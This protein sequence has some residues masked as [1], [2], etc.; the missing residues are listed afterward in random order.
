MKNERW[1]I[2]K[3]SLFVVS[4][5]SGAGK[6]TLCYEVSK[7]IPD[8]KYSIS[9]TTR[10]PRSGE[11]NHRDY[12]F[13]TTDKFK[14]MIE[15]GEFAE[16]AEVHGNFY[17]TPIK[18]LN[19]L[20]NQNDVILDIDTQGAMQMKRRYGEGVYIFILPPS[21]EVLEERIRK[22]MANSELE[23][24]SRLKKAREEMA[25]YKEYEYVIINNV[26]SEARSELE[27]IILSE[28]CRR[29]RID[30]GWVE[31]LISSA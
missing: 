10:M 27:S 7:L 15:R 6:T 2:R 8:L 21:L 28:R 31:R 11:V 25:G 13:V 9:C 29:E 20:R 17:G 1:R 12:T 22:R 4:A 14:E 19:E 5:P 26:F 16:W 30:S 3:G 18:E 23:I 24:K